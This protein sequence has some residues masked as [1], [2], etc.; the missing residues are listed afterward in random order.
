MTRCLGD[1]AVRLST[2]LKP[3]EH[4]PKLPVTRGSHKLTSPE[5]QTGYIVGNTQRVG[6]FE[7]QVRY[8][9]IIILHDLIRKH[10][11]CSWEFKEG[12]DFYVI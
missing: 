12:I 3:T 1:Y 10:T 9:S 6:A 2:Y 5:F 11:V 8:I 4:L 7:I